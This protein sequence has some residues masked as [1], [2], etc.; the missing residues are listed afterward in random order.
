MEV[1]YFTILY[2]FCHAS[3]WICHG[4]TRAPH[5]EPP[6]P[7]PSLYHPSGSSQCTSPKQGGFLHGGIDQEVTSVVSWWGTCLS[8]CRNKEALPRLVPRI[9]LL[10]A[11]V[12]CPVYT[13]SAE[14]W[15]LMFTGRI[16]KFFLNRQWK[17]TSCVL[18][19]VVAVQSLGRVQLFVTP[20]TAAH[21]LSS[22]VCSNPCPLSWWCYQTIL[23]SATLFSYCL[24][25]FPASRSFALSWPLRWPKHWS[26]SFSSSPSYEY[27]RLIS[28]RIDWFDLLQC[29][30]LSNLLQ[31][32]SSKASIL[33]PSAFL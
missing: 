2:W 9:S 30:G 5:P 25:Y 16:L 15:N 29:K 27:S 6:L 24:Q 20:W 32:H 7:P 13:F 11:P 3:T 1:N 4:Y 18:L 22:G 28:F 10:L 33:Q 12:P 23:P 26:F 8:A 31:D 14:H 19:F 21:P 17:N